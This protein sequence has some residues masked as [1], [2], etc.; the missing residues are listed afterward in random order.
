MQMMMIEPINENKPVNIGVIV[1]AWS[2]TVLGM[3]AVLGSCDPA[4]QHFSKVIKIPLLNVWK[5]M[6]F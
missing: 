5:W 2:S 4:V 3:V 6:D 1:S